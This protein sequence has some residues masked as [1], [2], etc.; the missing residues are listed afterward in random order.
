MTDPST[1]APAA[2]HPTIG[3]FHTSARPPRRALFVGAA[4]VPSSCAPLGELAT[5]AI[6]AAFNIMAASSG[7]RWVFREGRRLLSTRF[8]SSRPLREP[9]PRALAVLYAS[10]ARPDIALSGWNE[11]KH[12]INNSSS[13]SHDHPTGLESHGLP[14]ETE[15]LQTGGLSM[16]GSLNH[17]FQPFSSDVLMHFWWAAPGSA[18]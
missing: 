6:I 12:N 5:A 4:A 8:A 3:R 13:P 17:V 1:R 11:R 9:R 2:T 18:R 15:R 7:P 10:R 14:L 16:N